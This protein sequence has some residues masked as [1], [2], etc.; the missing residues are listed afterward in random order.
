MNYEIGDTVVHWT[1]GLGTV[2]EIDEKDLAG[3]TQQYYVIQVEQ[4][5]LWVSVEEANKGSIRLPMEKSQFMALLNILGAPGKRLPEQ[6][7][8]RKLEL[9]E[10]MQRTTLEDI[11]HVIRDLTD[12]SRH[13]T[14]NQNDAAV[15]FRAEELLLDEWVLALGIERTDAL[16]ELE[17]LL[18]NGVSETQ[19]L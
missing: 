1:H 10:R 8:Q 13:H 6:T 14:L 9:R 4:L 3:R 19:D 2:V 16:L 11:C 17:A 5:K 18:K 15:L 12:R 7:Y